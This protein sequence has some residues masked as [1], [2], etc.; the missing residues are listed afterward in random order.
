MRKHFFMPKGA[1]CA[2]FHGLFT[3]VE[4]RGKTVNTY[5]IQY[6]GSGH[7]L[8]NILPLGRFLRY[9]APEGKEERGAENPEGFGRKGEAKFVYEPMPCYCP[10]TGQVAAAVADSLNPRLF[11]PLKEETMRHVKSMAKQGY[12]KS[13]GVRSSKVSEIPG[14]VH[15]FEARGASNPNLAGIIDE[16]GRMVCRLD[17]DGW[18]RPESELAKR[19]EFIG[20]TIAKEGGVYRFSKEVSLLKLRQ[21]QAENRHFTF[22]DIPHN[23]ELFNNDMAHYFADLLQ[24][25]AISISQAE[26]ALRFHTLEFVLREEGLAALP[27]DKDRRKKVLGEY[28]RNV[29]HT[30]M[31]PVDIRVKDGE[32]VPLLWRVNIDEVSWMP[33]AAEFGEAVAGLKAAGISISIAIAGSNEKRQKAIDAE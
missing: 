21:I 29:F 9:G 33:T 12:V 1:E 28:G 15:F 19:A 5:V 18:N 24:S 4:G 30:G 25:E 20:I 3:M 16:N 23:F 7:R 8:R 10:H 31:I 14:T 17:M 6:T 27:D 13:G 2:V 22:G 32:R 11:T 26:A